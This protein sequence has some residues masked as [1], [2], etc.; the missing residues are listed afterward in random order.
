MNR[1]K[2]LQATSATVASSAFAAP[3][4][5]CSDTP[6]DSELADAREKYNDPQKVQ[7]IV[8]ERGPLL[9][10]LNSDDL[11]STPRVTVDEL[12]S[13]EDYLKS[14]DGARVWGVN[15]P[16]V[17]A[18]AHVT[19][20]RSVGDGQLVI[21]INPDLDNGPRAL[22]K[23]DTATSA[24]LDGQSV[25]RYLSQSRGE[26]PEK[27]RKRYRTKRPEELSGGPQTDS[28]QSATSSGD[29]STQGQIAYLC[30][31]RGGSGCDSYRCYSWEGECLGDSCDIYDCTG[32]L[33]HGG[34]CTCEEEDWC[35]E[36]CGDYVCEDD[37]CD[38]VSYPC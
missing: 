2:F 38:N 24:T 6:L 35:C 30:R 37:P 17:G 36:V 26:A 21:A 18:T 33:C 7:E 34:C 29:V 22:V 11:L 20:R 5:A 27:V 10:A 15:Y 28:T 4:V 25:T 8:N 9:G 14:S 16:G 19:V 23:R 32:S 13:V 12:L 3:A 1:R 31:N